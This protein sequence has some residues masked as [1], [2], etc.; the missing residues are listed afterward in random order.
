MVQETASRG[1]TLVYEKGDEALRTQLV[2]DLVSAFTGNQT[3]MNVDQDTELFDAGALPTGDGQSV[4]SYKDIVNVAS[5]VGGQT[6]IYKFMSLASNAATWSTCSAFGHFGLSNIISN[7]EVDP[8]LYPKLY[9][10]R[11]DPNPNFQ[12]SMNNIWKATVKEPTAILNQHF[13]LIMEDLLENIVG[14]EWRVREASCSAISDLIQGR[15]Y[16]QYERYYSTLWVVSLKVIDDV[17]GSVR[18]AALDLCMVLSKTLIR[19][20]ENSSEN[21]S[22]KAMMG[23][24]L[25]PPEYY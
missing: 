6:L 23:Q 19:T 2:E 13:D 9:H 21:T 17:K 4:T 5:E 24:A 8:K 18:K 10:Y 12:R 15:K 16:S 1:L 7:T 22:T 11:F 25:E 20:L 14:K 3:R